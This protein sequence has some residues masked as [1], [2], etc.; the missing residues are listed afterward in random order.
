MEYKD[1]VSIQSKKQICIQLEKV[2]R[3]S[4]SIINDLLA[5]SHDNNFELLSFRFFFYNVTYFMSRH[6]SRPFRSPW[7]IWRKR[8]WCKYTDTHVA[9]CV[10]SIKGFYLCPSILHFLSVSAKLWF[11]NF[12]I[13]KLGKIKSPRFHL[14]PLFFFFFLIVCFLLKFLLDGHCIWYAYLSVLETISSI[15]QC[16]FFF[17]FILW[18]L[19]DLFSKFIFIYLALLGLSCSVQDLLVVASG[20][21]FPD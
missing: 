12:L 5:S 13:W 10:M 21:K 6:P 18:D 8:N 9:C 4:F 2:G 20:I 15:C 17:P 11:A 19:D 1:S 3:V 7:K 16:F 14:C